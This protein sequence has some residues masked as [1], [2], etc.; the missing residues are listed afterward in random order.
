M[1]L[2]L[3]RLL[4]FNKSFVF[5]VQLPGKRVVGINMMNTFPV[6]PETKQVREDASFE[7]GLEN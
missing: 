7:G 6:F 5:F 4:V 2:P 3:S 1:R